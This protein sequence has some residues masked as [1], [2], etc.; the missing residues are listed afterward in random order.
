ME[1]I[2]QV[3]IDRIG[4]MY[5]MKGEG[6]EWRKEQRNS[7]QEEQNEQGWTGNVLWRK[8]LT[9]PWGW[10]E[11]AQKSQGGRDRDVDIWE[12]KEL[13]ML[14]MLSIGGK[15]VHMLYLA[16]KFMQDNKWLVPCTRSA[17]SR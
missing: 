6:W 10:I 15:M 16:G 13:Q 4:V 12:E 9:G 14:Q 5:Q 7:E 11:V 17:V 3:V 2:W 1:E 8:N